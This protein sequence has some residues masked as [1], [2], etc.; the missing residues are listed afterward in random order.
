M[1]IILKESRTG[2]IKFEDD[3]EFLVDYLT[4][5]QDAKLKK[6]LY[7]MGFTS[8]KLDNI[9]SL[10]PSERASVIYLSELYY[11][12]YFKY[13]VKDWR[14]IKDKEGNPISFKM[15]GNEMNTDLWQKFCRAVPLDDIFKIVKRIKEQ[16]ELT[17]DDK[18]K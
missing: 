18:K 1:N 10:S 15:S 17:E 6:I 13:A 2:W 3:I 16:V 7:E 9:E 8:D 5:D 12:Y 14:G 4:I 11:K